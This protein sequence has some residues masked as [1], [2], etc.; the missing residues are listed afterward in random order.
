MMRRALSG[1]LAHL[2]PRAVLRLLA[3]GEAT[4]RLELSTPSAVVVLRL[5]RGLVEPLDTPDMRALCGVLDGRTGEFR[6]EPAPP[7]AAPE[8]SLAVTALFEACREAGRATPHGFSSDLDVERLLV[9]NVGRTVGRPEPEIHLL[10]HHAPEDPLEDMLAE[11]EASAP[12]ELL[13]AQVGVV[14]PDPRP[15]R[16]SLEAE[17]KRRGWQLAL[18]GDPQGVPVEELELVVVHHSLSITRVG[19]EEDWLDL[20]RRA[21]TSEPPVPVV[22]VG[23]L[24]DPLWV[25]RLVQAGVAFLLPAPA[26][27]TGRAWERFQTALTAVVARQMALSC[28]RSK[29]EGPSAAGQLV[30]ALL[31]E[32][33]P[34]EGVSTLL[35]LAAHS[36]TRGAV[37][38]V[39]EKAVRC[40]AGFGYPLGQETSSLPRGVGILERVIRSKEALTVLEPAVGGA[41]QLA[42]VLGVEELPAHL[43][44]VPLSSG[45][46]VTGLLVGDRDGEP[47]G[48]LDELV[49]LARRLGGALVG[50]G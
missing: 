38:V 12:E 5:H 18:H 10:G 24:G 21:G 29:G 3:A 33:G 23:P 27:D 42:R 20:I 19:R 36:F 46:V 35:Q 14:T 47:L 7:D 25:A 30:E 45:G 22:W 15:W 13:F 43:A 4:G 16:G 9:E 44:V 26:G 48:D 49:L 28:G 50:S 17:W 41:R 34:D 11:L 6:F 39:E 2:G 32:T 8:G 1:D 40:R 31:H 37:F